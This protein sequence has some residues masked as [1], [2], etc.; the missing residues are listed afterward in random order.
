MIQLWE[1]NSKA[2]LKKGKGKGKKIKGV[3]FLWTDSSICELL[4]EWEKLRNKN[5]RSLWQDVATNLQN[6]K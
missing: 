1:N 5:K 3:G 4:H 6:K 2:S